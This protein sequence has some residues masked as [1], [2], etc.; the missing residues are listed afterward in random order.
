MRNLKVGMQVPELTAKLFQTLRDAE[1]ASPKEEI[2]E[3]AAEAVT[4]WMMAGTMN[5]EQLEKVSNR[6]TVKLMETGERMKSAILES[7]ID[8]G[9]GRN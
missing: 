7:I 3:C 8:A 6:F 4:I 5:A 1:E 2:A 9:G